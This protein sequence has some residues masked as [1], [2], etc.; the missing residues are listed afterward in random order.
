MGHGMSQQLE[1]V[2]SKL[3]DAKRSGGTWYARCPAHEDSRPSLSIT[4]GQDGRVLLTC[5]AG[6]A[7]EAIMKALDL[8]VKEAMPERVDRKPRKTATP[9]GLL[10]AHVKAEKKSGT[11]VFRTMEDAIAHLEHRLGKRDHLWIYRST[12]GEPIGAIL[13]W[14]TP[15]G[16]EIRPVS[17]VA[18]GWILGGMPEPRLIYAVPDLLKNPRQTVFVTEGEKAADEAI[19]LG[20]L[21]TTSPHGSKSAGKADWSPLA[22]RTVV[23]LP[24][25]DVPGAK[26]AEDVAQCLRRLT[27]PPSVQILALPGLPKGGDIV[28]YAQE[29]RKQGQNDDAIRATIEKLAAE[30]PAIAARAA[31]ASQHGLTDMGN[32]RRLIAAHGADLRYCE[33]IGGWFI[34]RDGCW[35][36]DANGRIFH[37]IHDTVHQ[38]YRDAAR[39]EDPDEAEALVKHAERSQSMRSV[40]SMERMARYEP[41]VIINSSD[42][43]PDDYLFSVQNGT[44][45]LRTG[46]LR[47]HRREDLITHISPVKYVEGARHWAWDKLVDGATQGDTEIAEFLQRAVGYSLTGCTTEKVLFLLSGLT[48]SAKSTFIAVINIVMGS[49]AKTADFETFVQ[50][51]AGSMGP[52]N[53]IARLHDARLVSAQETD[54]GRRLAAALIKWLTGG[55]RITARYLFKEAFEFTPKFKLWLS[56]NHDPGVDNEDAAMWRRLRRIPFP[57]IP[58]PDQDESIRQALLHEEAA[59]IAVLAWAVEGAL[60]WK[61]VGLSPPSSILEATSEY[62]KEQDPLREFLE[63]HCEIGTGYRIRAHELRNAYATFCKQSGILR[64]LSPQQFNKRLKSRGCD[65]MR[66]GYGKF[67]V[68]IML[69]PPEYPVASTPGNYTEQ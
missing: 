26:Y 14:N 52:R 45:D 43:N 33:A 34:W 49:Y 53:D 17:L 10:P 64:P 37:R 41:E 67:W 60:M 31:E 8:D 38:M 50:Q 18:D 39:L 4:E 69:K 46:V 20:L 16:K 44:I 1:L 12:S 47:E 7:F 11:Q 9:R 58:E 13:R 29:L 65:Y 68:G 25:N 3:P 22:G 28:E 59:Q 30:A 40:L 63:D 2:I 61:E 62:R 36:T 66:D 55:D 24:D 23:L 19:L 57:Q 27:P 56:V 51:Q 32:S 5:H 48:G 6:C 15:K 21:A 54:E 35:R 42:F